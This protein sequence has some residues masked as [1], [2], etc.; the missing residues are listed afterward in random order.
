MENQDKI[1]QISA[2]MYEADS[3]KGQEVYGLSESGTLFLLT[4]V[5]G[6]MQWELVTESPSKK[7]E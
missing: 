7:P 4:N 2:V 5:Q 3:H 1:I 6:S